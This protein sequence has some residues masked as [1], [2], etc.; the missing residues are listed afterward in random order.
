MGIGTQ[1]GTRAKVACIKHITPTPETSFLRICRFVFGALYFYSSASVKLRKRIE[2]RKKIQLLQSSTFECVQIST[3]IPIT[4][5][6]FR[7]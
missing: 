1:N 4:H 6:K 7:L 2:K 5:I 3:H